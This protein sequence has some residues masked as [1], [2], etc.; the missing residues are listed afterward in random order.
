MDQQGRN[1]MLKALAKALVLRP[2][3]RMGIVVQRKANMPPPNPQLLERPL[4]GKVNALVLDVGASVGQSV[5]RVLR[6]APEAQVISF[7]PLAD[8]FAFL[9][10]KYGEC[11]N[12]TLV[13]AAVGDTDGFITIYPNRHSTSSSVLRMTDVC[14]ESYSHLAEVGEEVVRLVRLD[15]FLATA[16]FARRTYDL[17]KIDVQGYE[18][19]VLQGASETLK[20]CEAVLLEA[21]LLD[22][23]D[24]QASIDA[25]VGRLRQEG[26]SIVG[27]APGY[28]HKRT[29]DLCQ[30][31]LLFGK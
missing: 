19:R 17:L 20:V 21:S 18:D 6:V 14:R 4:Q 24:G 8:A 12:V 30:V 26:F 1:P 3:D 15:S 27:A 10:R 23:Y 7:E 28:R 11:P 29:H 5:E 9:Q 2:L 13:H 31:D 16:A 22:L 25:L